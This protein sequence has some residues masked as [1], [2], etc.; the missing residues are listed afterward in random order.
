MCTTCGGLMYRERLDN[1][2]KCWQ[3]GRSPTTRHATE[4]DSKERKYDTMRGGVA[5]ELRRLNDSA[6]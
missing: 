6:S 2:L 4:R 5:R 3:C 1:D